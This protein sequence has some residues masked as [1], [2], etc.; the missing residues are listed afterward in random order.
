M[1]VSYIAY[2]DATLKLF[3]LCCLIL[4]LLFKIIID[5]CTFDV[6]S[7]YRYS[8]SFFFLILFHLFYVCVPIFND[9]QTRRIVI[10]LYSDWVSIFW[11]REVIILLVTVELIKNVKRNMILLS[12][13]S[14]VSSLFLCILAFCNCIVQPFI[15]MES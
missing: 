8:N 12:P 1:S 6:W 4:V 9:Y 13:S 14:T 10:N 5:V 2:L 3:T 7:S 11:N 15:A